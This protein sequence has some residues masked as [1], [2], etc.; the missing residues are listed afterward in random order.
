VKTL[1]SAIMLSLLATWTATGICPP[2]PP[3]LKPPLP[4]VG[5]SDTVHA[6]S[7]DSVG[8]NCRWLW[9][10]VK[11]VNGMQSQQDN[12]AI[13]NAIANPLGSATENERREAQAALMR[14]QA[15]LVQ[16]QTEALR[17]ENAAR[18]HQ[19]EQQNIGSQARQGPQT[20]DRDRKIPDYYQTAGFLNGYW[21]THASFNSLS[22]YLR[23]YSEHVVGF[24]N[25]PAA[26]P[27][28]LGQKEGDW[29]PGDLTLAEIASRVDRFYDDTANLVI[30]IRFAVHVVAMQLAGRSASE[31]YAATLRYR[32]V[33]V[34]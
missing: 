31:I 28:F 6:C 5:Y 11:G 17:L 10:G 27:D 13:L 22:L 15:A 3:D 26:M 34:Q 1:T 12:S 8:M 16:Q 30:P 14:R 7:C 18:Q 29:W 2:E 23:G 4:P 32:L 20:Q 24:L 21:W 19:L 9:V 33:G 25:Q